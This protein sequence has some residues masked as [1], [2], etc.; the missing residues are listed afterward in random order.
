MLKVLA[1]QCRA[2][3]RWIKLF[4]SAC[5]E[6]ERAWREFHRT[7]QSLYGACLSRAEGFKPFKPNTLRSRYHATAI[8]V[9][10]HLQRR[11]VYVDLKVVRARVDTHPYE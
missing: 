7:L 10:E 3:S 9:D 2:T 4:K 6:F 11:R 1:N 5:G 8:E